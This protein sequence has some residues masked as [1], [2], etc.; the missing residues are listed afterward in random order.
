MTSAEHAVVA[1]SASLPPARGVLILAAVALAFALA[2]N[3]PAIWGLSYLFQR[4]EFY[5]HG[6]LIPVVAAYLAYG[7]RREIREA[8]RQLRPPVWGPMIAVAA[9]TFEVLMLIGDVGFAAGLGIPLVLGAA[10]YGIGGWALLRPLALPLGFL[11][12]MVPPPRFVIYELL[13]RLKLIVTDM[14][15]WILQTGGAPV[16]GEGNRILV[17]GHTL[18]VSDACSGLTS[19]VTLLPVACIL[20]YFMTWGIWRRALVVASVVPLTMAANV[21]RVIVTVQLVSVI[22]AEAAQG[23]LHQSFGIATYALGTA[24]LVGV[25]RLLR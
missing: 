1:D 15:V 12:L 23:I 22:G 18:F 20:A 14:A 10:F 25:A 16:L 19:I 13:F 3:L 24:A 17:P 4:V 8:L 11:V 6:F 2:L 9:G 5:G 21:I 7:A